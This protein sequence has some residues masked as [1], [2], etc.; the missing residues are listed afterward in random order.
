M[1]IT[2][3]EKVQDIVQSPEE[4]AEDVNQFVQWFED[5][6]PAMMSFGIKVVL[7]IVFFF[8]GRAVIHGDRKSVV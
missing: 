8:I 6:I 3:A 4:V 7:A 1:I 2:A 5:Q